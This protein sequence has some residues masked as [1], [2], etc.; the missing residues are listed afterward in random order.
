MTTRNPLAE[1][2]ALQTPEPAAIVIFGV[3]GDLARRKLL[4]ALYR[5]F[6]GRRL[7]F[8]T[9]IVGVGRR[10]WG[11]A[12]LVKE[13]QASLEQSTEINKLDPEDWARFSGSLRYLRGEFDQPDTYKRLG[14]LLERLNLPS[15]LFYLSTPPAEFEEIA[16]GLHSADL[17]GSGARI[18]IEKPFGVNVESARQ[19]NA[20]LHAA[21]D[22]SNVYRID[23]FLGKETVQ[24]ILALRFGNAIF[25]PL[26]NRQFVERVE[27]TVAEDLGMEGRGAFYEEAGILRDMI[28]NHALQLLTLTAME[29]PVARPQS[30][31]G[32]LDAG[33]LRDEKVKVLHAL[34]RLTASP[35]AENVVL[36]QYVAGT[37]YGLP[38]VGYREEDHV[39]ADSITPTFAALRVF[40]DNWRWSGVPFYLRSGKRL[41][42]KGTEIALVFRR[43]PQALFPNSS[44]V[45]ALT[46]NI[47]PDEGATLRFMA[48]Q[49]GLQPRLLPVSMDFSYSTFASEAP[50]AYERLVLDALSGDASLFPR[51]DEVEAAWEWIEPLIEANLTPKPYEAGAWGPD[52]ADRLMSDGQHWRQV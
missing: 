9:V 34:R 45:N 14:T 41:P 36:G 33:A 42:R 7:G 31:A 6:V 2:G 8:G 18:V 37:S 40:V 48:K 46:I 35:L 30:G 38:V 16:V 47:Q 24:N 25:E 12:G 13:T 29:P 4:P 3:T 1:A 20:A 26:W 50:T 32:L 21:F 44:E 52:E 49:P 27:I 15:R 11:D 28:Q 51:E 10:D 43:P 5:L 17:S 19:L 22:E 23:H 39:A